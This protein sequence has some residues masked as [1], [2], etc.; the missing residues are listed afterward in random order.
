[1]AKEYR[2]LVDN[3]LV[4]GEPQKLPTFGRT[5]QSSCARWLGPDTQW[6]WQQ[7]SPWLRAQAQTLPNVHSQITWQPQPAPEFPLVSPST[8]PVMQD[9]V[10]TPRESTEQS[11][12]QK[13]LQSSL[14]S[15]LQSQPR[16][17]LPVPAPD[18]APQDPRLNPQMYR[19][20]VDRCR[21]SCRIRKKK[22]DGRQ[23]CRACA[24][25]NLE[26]EYRY[27]PRRREETSRQAI[28]T[29][30]ESVNNL[31]LRVISLEEAI[32]NIKQLP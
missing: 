30:T 3:T 28:D 13:P 25:S 5:L 27:L 2:D 1:M 26:C 31:T 8:Q 18:V 15:S 12:G 17:L 24:E 23:P 7:N 4:E 11:L 22:C 29:L 19:Y 6:S 14:Q 9:V 32:R 16:I 10:Q 20:H 21:T